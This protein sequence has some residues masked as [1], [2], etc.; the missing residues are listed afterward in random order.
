M[1]LRAAA[2]GVA[3]GLVVPVG[4]GEDATP[5]ADPSPPATTSASSPATSSSPAE[6]R[7]PRSGPSPGREPGTTIVAR[8]SRFG[9]ILFDEAGQA[10]YLFDVERTARPQ[11]YGACATAWPPVYAHGRPRAG[12]SVKESLLGTTTRRDGRAQVTYGGHPLYYYAHEAP[13]EVE[14]HDVFLNGGYWYAV[15]PDGDRAP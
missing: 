5:V 14:C 8:P 12:D 9:P 3:L 7:S 2:C 11:C 1:D 4:C 6:T 13:G 15:A 10:I